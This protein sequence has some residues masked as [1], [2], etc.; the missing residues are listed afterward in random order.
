MTTNSDSVPSHKQ[1]LVS[2]KG[3][4]PHDIWPI[5]KQAIST[6]ETM[7]KLLGENE[8]VSMM[9]VKIKSKAEFYIFRKNDMS[10]CLP[11]SVGEQQNPQNSHI[12]MTFQNVAQTHLDRIVMFVKSIS[13]DV[14]KSI[15]NIL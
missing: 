14:Q 2:K 13:P 11:V 3:I 1:W 9:K 15:S 8:E 12:T 5:I 4:L 7:S 6:F 10:M